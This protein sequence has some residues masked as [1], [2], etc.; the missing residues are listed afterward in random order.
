M[1]ATKGGRMDASIKLNDGRIV[2]SD[3]LRTREGQQELSLMRE[4][5]ERPECLC[6]PKNSHPPSLQVKKLPSGVYILA[7]MPNTQSQH[8]MHCRNGQDHTHGNDQSPPTTESFI[9]NEDGTF[10][11]NSFF[12]L[13]KTLKDTALETVGG[14]DKQLHKYQGKNTSTLLGLLHILWNKAEVNKHFPKDNGQERSWNF[15]AYFIKKALQLGRIKGKTMSSVIFINQWK[16]KDG[17]LKDFWSWTHGLADQNKEGSVGVLIG[18]VA[19]LH[20]AAPNGALE[21]RLDLIPTYIKLGEAASRDL[22]TSYPRIIDKL[23]NTPS[24]RDRGFSVVGIF[25][26]TNSTRI[27]NKGQVKKCLL[28]RKGA[29][30]M[31]STDY[32]PVESDYELQMANALKSAKRLFVKPIRHDSESPVFPDFII[33]DEKPATFVEVFGI[34]NDPDYEKRKQEKLNYYK[35]THKRLITWDPTANELI[36]EIP[37]PPPVNKG[38]TTR[39]D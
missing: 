34:A 14:E 22:L 30:M 4:A 25:L 13:E 19:T 1:A 38:D 35:R 29:L 9:E 5:G 11:V 2:T 37:S 6:N 31:T 15:T 24:Q 21:L 20:Q 8:A 23:K 33:I 26:V 39:Q 16:Q 36:P 12:S 27:D 18:R 17:H 32:I 7:R 10:E 28:A 3:W